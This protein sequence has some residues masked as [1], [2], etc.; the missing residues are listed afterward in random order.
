MSPDQTPVTGPWLD[1]PDFLQFQGPGGYLCQ[2]S[3]GH[4]DCLCGYVALPL[5]HPLAGKPFT[6]IDIRVHAGWTFSDDH[7]PRKRSKSQWVIGFSC[8]TIEDY[9]PFLPAQAQYI[10][11]R[12]VEAV[13]R[14]KPTY[15][16]ISF[17]RAELERV[18]KELAL[19]AIPQ[20]ETP[21]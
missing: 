8:S 18:C 6:D 19:L 10:L 1:E 21:A 14:P 15:K 7:F 9:V 4:A 2:I 16:D 20:K 12:M 17:V 13:G 5:T 3:R 11:E